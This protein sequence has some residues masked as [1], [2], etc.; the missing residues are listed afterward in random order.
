M[1]AGL[2]GLLGGIETSDEEDEDYVPQKK[3]KKTLI[4]KSGKAKSSEV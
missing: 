2:G 3:K 1:C 4:P